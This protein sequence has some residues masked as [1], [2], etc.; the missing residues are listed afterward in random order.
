MWDI[1]VQASLNTLLGSAISEG[2]LRV[3]RRKSFEFMSRK[4]AAVGKEELV[5]THEIILNHKKNK[6]K[7]TQ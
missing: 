4:T 5:V 2:Y 7:S 3:S 1:S 6:I